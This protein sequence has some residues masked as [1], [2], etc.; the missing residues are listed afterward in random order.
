[1]KVIVAGPRALRLYHPV[2]NAIEA[3]EYEITEVVS[4]GAVGADYCGEVWAEQN[5]IPL[6]IMR[7]EYR[8]YNPKI[9]PLKRNE[10]M[11]KYADAAVI[12]WDGKSRGTAHMI[13]VMENLK[14]PHFIA[15]Y[16]DPLWINP[17][18]KK[19]DYET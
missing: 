7:P 1:M 5:K 15:I 18:Y 3:S 4:G 13:S 16:Y 14:K 2:E 10:K 8:K 9:A 12:V 11:G 19:V 17:V 6:T